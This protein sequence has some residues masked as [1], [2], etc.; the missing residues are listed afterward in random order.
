MARG[1]EELEKGLMKL[2]WHCY[3]SIEEQKEFKIPQTKAKAYKS[4]LYHT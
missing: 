1:E 2:P 4:K 3:F